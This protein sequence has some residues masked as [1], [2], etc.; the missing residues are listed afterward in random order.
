[1]HVYYTVDL[2]VVYFHHNFDAISCKTIKKLQIYIYS[3]NCLNI[4]TYI[5]KTKFEPLYLGKILKCNKR[6][7][8]KYID[9]RQCRMK[10][11]LFHCFKGKLHKPHT[12]A[13]L[14]RKKTGRV[15]VGKTTCA[16]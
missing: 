15:R 7:E 3:M 2:K 11:T 16:L 14:K 1:M 4:L 5:F 6:R 9:H 10:K 13:T 12:H 8:I